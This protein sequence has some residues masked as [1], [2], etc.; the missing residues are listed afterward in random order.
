MQKTKGFDCGTQSN[1][2]VTKKQGQY[3]HL[4]LTQ[5]LYQ[6]C[7]SLPSKAFSH[8]NVE[9]LSLIHEKVFRIAFARISLRLNTYNLSTF[10]FLLYIFRKIKYNGNFHHISQ[11]GVL[12]PKPPPFTCQQHT[13]VGTTHIIFDPET[14]KHL[15]MHAVY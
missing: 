7:Q 15:A 4:S 12:L 14:C 11:E 2:H 6:F 10:S 5:G 8:R 9:E 13:S 1:L 3:L